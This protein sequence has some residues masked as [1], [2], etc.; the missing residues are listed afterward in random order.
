MLLWELII[1]KTQTPSVALMNTLQKTCK[2]YR[3]GPIGK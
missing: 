3:G 1:R 2:I